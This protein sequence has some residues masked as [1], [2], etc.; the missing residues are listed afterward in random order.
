MIVAKKD[1]SEIDKDIY[2]TQ[3]SLVENF[4][5]VF[6]YQNDSFARRFYFYLS[7]K[8]PKSRIYFEHFTRRMF[9]MLY[10]AISERSRIAFEFYDFDNDERISSLDIYDL[11]RYYVK[12]SKLHQEASAIV[13]Y[14]TQLSK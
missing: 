14:I 9:N 4:S 3:E 11:Y 12:G 2:I 8:S 10:G 6:G 7:E 5:K 1:V 13:D